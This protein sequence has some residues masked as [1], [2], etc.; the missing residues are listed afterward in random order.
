MGVECVLDECECDWGGD[1]LSGVFVSELWRCWWWCPGCWQLSQPHTR[2]HLQSP[3]PLCVTA[4]A[5]HVSCCPIYHA[6]ST[7]RDAKKLAEKER[8][9]IEKALRCVCLYCTGSGAVGVFV[10][11]VLSERVGN[12]WQAAIVCVPAGR[13][14]FH[15]PAHPDLSPFHLPSTNPPAPPPHLHPPQDEG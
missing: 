7:E 5:H 1:C 4:H 10:V 3:L 15:S 8:L 2:L 11:Y 13:P 9:A 12:K 14:A 6:Q